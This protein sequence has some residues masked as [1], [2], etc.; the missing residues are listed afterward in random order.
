MYLGAAPYQ[1][2]K[3]C[4]CSLRVEGG[5]LVPASFLPGSFPQLGPNRTHR[6][7]VNASPRLILLLDSP[8]LLPDVSAFFSS[9]CVLFLFPL[10][11][12]SHH[13]AEIA[14]NWW[15]N[16]SSSLLETSPRVASHPISL[17]SH[18]HDAIVYA[19]QHEPSLTTTTTILGE[20][21]DGSR[22]SRV[23]CVSLSPCIRQVPAILTGST[24][25][26]PTTH[27]VLR[28]EY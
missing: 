27:S 10:F 19:V 18:P 23:R 25:L 1:A 16:C 17:S 3:S 13:A 22:K 8:R 28:G 15:A 5:K 12:Y 21:L 6:T 4:C 24:W 20:P 14:A 26:R 11:R 2:R 9:S 7:G